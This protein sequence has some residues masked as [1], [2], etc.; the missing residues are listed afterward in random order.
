MRG[1]SL[2]TRPV[3]LVAAIRSDSSG[4]FAMTRQLATPE[5][6]YVRLGDAF[7]ILSA[8]LLSLASGAW[9]IAR[10]EFTL[11]S[12]ILAALGTYCTLLV[13]HLM[14]RRLLQEGETED[15][16]AGEGDVHWQS[17][18]AA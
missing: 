12:A 14:A 18:A 10:L 17:G 6:L 2:G 8:T 13:L 9:L 3:M 15:D 11:S 1:C 4:G 7:V 16:S 5:P